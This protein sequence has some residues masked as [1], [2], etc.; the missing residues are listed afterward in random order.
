M[1]IKSFIER[2]KNMSRKSLVITGIILFFILSI[3]QQQSAEDSYNE[4]ESQYQQQISEL[5]ETVA[6]KQEYIN[7][8][9]TSLEEMNSNVDR[10]EYEDWRLV[11]PDVY[12][13]A[14]ELHSNIQNEP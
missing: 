12:H 5:E 1:G 4:M 11:V 14:K 2:M 10:F 8:M 3:L 6:L 7:G 13:K 9:N